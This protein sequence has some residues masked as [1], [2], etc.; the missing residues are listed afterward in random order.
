MKSSVKVVRHKRSC[1]KELTAASRPTLAKNARWTRARLSDFPV[2]PVFGRN[3]IRGI[4]ETGRPQKHNARRFPRCHGASEV[5]EVFPWDS[6]DLH[7]CAL[8]CSRR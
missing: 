6:Y 7:S 1:G 2:C 5:Q 3:T 8:G 4:L